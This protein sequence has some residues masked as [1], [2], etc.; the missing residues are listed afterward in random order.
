MN[1]LLL[2]F[3]CSKTGSSGSRFYTNNFIDT[4]GY[5]KIHIVYQIVS[6]LVSNDYAKLSGWLGPTSFNAT[7]MAAGI[8]HESFDIVSGSNEKLYFQN[9]D[10]NMKILQVWLSKD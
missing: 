5:T 3:N 9:Y 2:R 4:T 8:Y 10:A 7:N 6:Q 1:L